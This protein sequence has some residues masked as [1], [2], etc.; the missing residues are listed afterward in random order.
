MP[1]PSE[2]QTQIYNY[3]ELT[4]PTEQWYDL[5]FFTFIADVTL[6]KRLIVEHKNARKIY[7]FFEGLAATEDFRLAQ[8]KTQVI[9]YVSIQEAVINYT[10][11]ELFPNSIEVGKLITKKQFKEYSIPNASREKLKSELSHDGKEIICGYHTDTIVDKTKIRYEEKLKVCC[12]LNLISPEL[13][14]ELKKLYEYRNTVH[15]EAELRKN[16]SFDL[17]MGELAYRRVEGLSIVLSQN[18]ANVEKQ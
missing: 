1:F 2:L 7:K 9:M 18:I 4:L 8:I 17:D 14:D 12:E 5:N 13:A 16:L 11:F 6:R 15:L 3:L 10:L